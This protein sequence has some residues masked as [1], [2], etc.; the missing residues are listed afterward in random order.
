MYLEKAM[1]K[2]LL[3]LNNLP[4]F[5]DSKLYGND[6]VIVSIK[7][8]PFGWLFHYNGRLAMETNDIEATYMGVAPVLVDK[9]DESVQAVRFIDLR[10]QIKDYIELKGYNVNIDEFF[11]PY[12]NEDTDYSKC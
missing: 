11:P 6:P 7:E 12:N 1:N 2:T 5:R 8:L 9:N 10:E 3:Y 4:A